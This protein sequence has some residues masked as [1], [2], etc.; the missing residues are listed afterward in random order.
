MIDKNRQWASIDLLVIV[1]Q[2]SAWLNADTGAWGRDGWKE[3]GK[4]SAGKGLWVP[5]MAGLGRETAK[6]LKSR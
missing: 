3:E 4:G 2:L 6:V 5:W 1:G